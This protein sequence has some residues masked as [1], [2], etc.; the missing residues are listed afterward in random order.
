MDSPSETLGSRVGFTSICRR[1][2]FC[3]HLVSL[4]ELEFYTAENSQ[5]GNTNKTLLSMIFHICYGPQQN[6]CK[7]KK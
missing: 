6:I 3:N 7:G 4:N 5:F 2:Y 1:F